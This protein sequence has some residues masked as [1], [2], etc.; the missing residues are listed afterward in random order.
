MDLVKYAK[1]TVDRYEWLPVVILL[2]TGALLR[3]Y[4]LGALPYGLNQ[5][6][7]SAGYDAW[8][9]LNY[10]IDRC[11]NSFPVLLEAWGS[12]QN[13]LYSYLVMPFIAIFGLTEFSLRLPAAI[14]GTAALAVFWL[15]A[16]KVRGPYF[17]LCALLVLAV[18]PWHVM[19]SRWALES[20]I[21]PFFLFTGMLFTLLSL[22]REWYL[23]PAAVFFALSLY[24]Y[25]TA[26]FFLPLF[27]TGAVIILRKKLRPASFF[28]SFAA[29]ILIAMPIAYCQVL[30][31]AGEEST[32]F[33]GMTLP[34]LTESR[35]MATTVFGGGGADALKTNFSK[36]LAILRT[37][38]DGMKYNSLGTGGMFGVFGLPLIA[39]GAIA[40]LAN[41]K[42]YTGERTVRLAVLAGL[43]TAF[44]IDGNINRLNMLWLPLIYFEAVGL[45]WILCKLKSFAV[46]PIAVLA[47]STVLFW[48][49]YT[50]TMGGSGYALYFPGLGEAIEYVE[51]R[52][53]ESVFIT[54]YVN[55][56]YIFSLF[57][58]RTDPN[59]FL[60]TVD[61]INPDGA[62]RAVRSYGKYSF[63]AAEYGNA[64][65]L[66]VH[67]SEVG[68]REEEARF[69]S[70]A[71]CRGD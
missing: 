49:S 21:L 68:D 42:R 41:R 29:F 13:V 12:G 56:P 9:L 44:F 64:D 30:N 58:S 7:A 11:G 32:A 31:L 19:I 62:F 69:G 66:I 16:R 48:N 6:E 33:L 36:L 52:E 27:L 67:V 17:A 23:L 18:N 39:L 53:P 26:F 51:Q 38:T 61:Y 25:G 47:A 1:R 59:E 24:C 35:Q 43:L 15:F 22:D 63:G 2:L 70:Y 8:A 34:R 65:Y 46:I 55:Q 28:V 40:S 3:F 5:D 57:Y 60:S 10:G 14:L 4:S 54:R 50:D 37:Q 71:V 45:Y 20:N